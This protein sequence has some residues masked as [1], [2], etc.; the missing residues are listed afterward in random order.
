MLE[1]RVDVEHVK[2]GTSKQYGVWSIASYHGDIEGA[3]DAFDADSGLGLVN[4]LRLAT[5]REPHTK[6]LDPS[7]GQAKV[8]CDGLVNDVD[9]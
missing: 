2:G 8:F 4:T 9:D 3:R 5:I 6:R 1:L 7:E